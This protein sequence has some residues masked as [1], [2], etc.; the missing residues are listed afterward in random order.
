MLDGTLRFLTAMRER[1]KTANAASPAE[2][3]S[4]VETRQAARAENS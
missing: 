1:A 4:P 2:R 3:F